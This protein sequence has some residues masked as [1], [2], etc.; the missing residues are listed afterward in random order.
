M[1]PLSYQGIWNA[2]NEAI[3]KD[4][5]SILNQV[6]TKVVSDFEIIPNDEVA[7]TLWNIIVQEVEKSQPCEYF[8]GVT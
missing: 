6:V 4:K 7:H 2:R 3:F 1:P 8:D 5:S